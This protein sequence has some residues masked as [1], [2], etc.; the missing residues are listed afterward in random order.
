MSDYCSTEHF[1]TVIL[2]SQ[3]RMH[4]LKCELIKIQDTPAL[5]TYDP[6]QNLAGGNA[7]AHDK[8]KP[9]VRSY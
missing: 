1:G 2:V 4:V 5:V 8:C 9:R 7:D 6:G 3:C